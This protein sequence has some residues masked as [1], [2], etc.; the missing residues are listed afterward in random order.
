[1]HFFGGVEERES[2]VNTTNGDIT[3]DMFS[4]L[5]NRPIPS[6][7]PPQQQQHVRSFRCLYSPL[8]HYRK[9]SQVTEAYML[10]LICFKTFEKFMM[11]FL[12]QMFVMLYHFL[13]LLSSLLSQVPLP[14]FPYLLYN[15]QPPPLPSLSLYNSSP[16]QPPFYLT[17]PPPRPILP[18]TTKATFSTTNSTTTSSVQGALWRSAL[19]LS[20]WK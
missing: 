2:F 16:P 6:P 10:S 3:R 1:M 14:L 9:K 18:L 7:P 19:V 12:L 11:Y 4:H 8:E 20:T 13:F 5:Y 17:H 15:T